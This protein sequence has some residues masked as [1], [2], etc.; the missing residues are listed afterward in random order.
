MLLLSMI[1]W[2]VQNNIFRVSKNRIL[3]L[4]LLI[5]TM[6]VTQYEIELVIKHELIV[7][8]GNSHNLHDLKLFLYTLAQMFLSFGRTILIYFNFSEYLDNL[9][10]NHYTSNLRHYH[11]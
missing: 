9:N 5:V 2:M 1:N 4:L 8:M 6:H 7:H 11:N 3:V 10:H